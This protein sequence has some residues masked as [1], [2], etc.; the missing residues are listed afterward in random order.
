M[1]KNNTAAIYKIDDEIMSWIGSNILAV[2]H[3][4]LKRFYSMSF[5]LAKQR[6]LA[7]DHHC[8]LKIIECIVYSEETESRRVWAVDQTNG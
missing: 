4:C 5:R 3:C 6:R 2:Y 8:T 7:I 1:T